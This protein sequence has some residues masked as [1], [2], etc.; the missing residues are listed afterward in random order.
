M[1]RPPNTSTPTAPKHTDTAE[2]ALP[3]DP[4]LEIGPIDFD[5]D[6]DHLIRGYN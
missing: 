3:E 6:D 4:P 2:H 1:T 5:E